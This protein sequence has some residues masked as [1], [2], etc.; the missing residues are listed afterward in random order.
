[1]P[2]FECLIC[3]NLTLRQRQRLYHS[4][5]VS[6]KIC[7][8][9]YFGSHQAITCRR[10]RRRNYDVDGEKVEGGR[11]NAICYQNVCFILFPPPPRSPPL[12]CGPALVLSSSTS[13]NAGPKVDSGIQ[14]FPSC[15]P[16][17][18]FL[19]AEF[20]TCI[21]GCHRDLHLSGQAI[22]LS[23]HHDLLVIKLSRQ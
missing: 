21:Q 22:H 18:P 11:K 9:Q 14:R 12:R 6:C 8:S 7:L 19:F 5:D 23:N 1:M 16:F 17:T 4:K 10:C 3:I 13:N 15:V 20:S 2:Q